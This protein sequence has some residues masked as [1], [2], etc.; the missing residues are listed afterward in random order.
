MTDD[1]SWWLLM[2][3][4]CFV[5]LILSYGAIRMHGR[6]DGP[7]VLW[8]G[9]IYLDKSCWGSSFKIWTES[10]I[11]RF[12]S[13]VRN[14]TFDRQT[15]IYCS[16]KDEQQAKQLLKIWLEN[17]FVQQTDARCRWSIVI[18]QWSMQWW[19]DRRVQICKWRLEWCN[20]FVGNIYHVLWSEGKPTLIPGACGQGLYFNNT[21]WNIFT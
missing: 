1:D 6:I 13:I 14:K 7:N 2:T 11:Y 15:S 18:G 20:C 10:D 5:W 16:T 19:P 12:S 3:L 8:I 9:E 21:W 17:T 4:W